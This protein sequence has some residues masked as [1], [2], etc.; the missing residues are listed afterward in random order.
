MRNGRESSNPVSGRKHGRLSAFIFLF[1]FL[2]AILTLLVWSYFSTGAESWMAWFSRAFSAGLCAPSRALLSFIAGCWKLYLAVNAV[3]VLF[4]LLG[5]THGNFVGVTQ[6]S[7]HWAEGEELKIFA[8]RGTNMPLADG[9]YLTPEAKAANKNV[10]VLASPGGGK[11]FTVIIPAIEAHTRE[12][13]SFFCTDTKG[14]LYRDT[15]KMV[16]ERGYRVYLLN[17]SDPWYS[18]RYNPLFNVHKERSVT[19]ISKLALSYTKNVRDEEA[20]VGDAIWEETFKQL[21]TAVWLY[22]YDFDV[23]PATG[24]PESRALWRTSEL[25]KDLRTGEDGKIDSDCELARIVEAIRSTDPLHPTVAGF[26]FVAAGASETIASVIITAGAKLQIFSYPEIEAM[27]RDND[28]P[29]DRIFEEN[30]AVYLN[31]EVGSPYKAIA[32]LFIEQLFASAY[33]VAETKHGGTLPKPFKLYFDELPNLCR[34]HS[35]PERLS[36]SRS[37]NVDILVSVQSMQQLR[38][39]FK[40][41]E[42]TLMN[43]CVVHVYL[44]SGEADA[45]KEISEALG[46]TTTQEISHSRARGLAGN[47]GNSDSDRA[48]GRELALPSELYSMPG[49][50][51]IVKIQNHPPI[52]AEKFHT[53][54]QRF[55]KLLGGQGNPNNSCVITKDFE[56][57]KLLGESEYEVEH[58]ERTNR[59]KKRR[60]S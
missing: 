32:A 50:Y 21:M 1:L 3:T 51:A 52:F 24:E 37:Y 2:N 7:A 40:E 46:K 22:Q 56:K 26:D 36:T 45:L 18:H 6:G 14:A 55:Y 8:D 10:F 17:L 4:F 43:N 15:A 5:G 16:R 13:G 19:E 48:H 33:Y 54:R 25:I 34:I 59:L 49:R 38:R 47:G 42:K 11:T 58:R 60:T 31:F 30:T 12:G 57:M 28:V 27:T 44:G 29:I 20:G 39:T 41:A 9:V 35:L 23:N 53:E